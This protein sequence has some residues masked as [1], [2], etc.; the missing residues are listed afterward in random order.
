MAVTPF[1][2]VAVPASVTVTPF[3]SVAVPASVA[4][5]FSSTG[6]PAERTAR[7]RER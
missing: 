3:A 1:A 6:G 5:A 2:S 4:V 7:L